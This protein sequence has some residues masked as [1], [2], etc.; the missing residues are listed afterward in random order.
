MWGLCSTPASL[1]KART[2]ISSPTALTTLMVAVAV[3]VM[4]ACGTPEPS[5]GLAGAGQANDPGLVHVHGLG[6]DP[7]DDT[8]YAATHTGLFR[9]KDGKAS[10]V[11]PSHD[12]MGFTV[13]GPNRFLA[14]GHPDLR[15]EELLV[16]GKPP[17]LGLVE[18]S[19]GAEWDALS[20]LGEADFHALE[21][22]DGTVFGWFNDQFWVSAN[23]SDWE[24]RSRV[25]MHDFAVSPNNGDIVATT[26]DGLIRSQDG[27]RSWEPVSSGG[28]TLVDWR[29]D[30][31][32][33]ASPAGEISI[34]DDGG[35]TWQR[36]GSVDGPVEAL[37]AT[38]DAV[39]A[40]VTGKGILRSDDGGASWDVVIASDESHS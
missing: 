28:Y 39:F 10:R 27:G 37:S 6:V 11:G 12:L 26:G 4:T 25:S 20:L 14:S 31:L 9:V 21:F 22:S 1:D 24:R 13:A 35:A 7:A 3:A 38:D 34:S 19:D 5:G 40:A 33:A 30:G 15:H 23:G 32:F 17:L 16:D 36:R 8:L 2:L 18:S 29:S